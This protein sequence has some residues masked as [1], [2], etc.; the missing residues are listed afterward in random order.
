LISGEDQAKIKFK[1][2]KF[3]QLNKSKTDSHKATRRDSLNPNQVLQTS[4]RSKY[5]IDFSMRNERKS[6][7]SKDSQHKVHVVDIAIEK[8]LQKNS[9][10][11]NFDPLKILP[12]LKKWKIEPI[13]VSPRKIEINILNQTLKHQSHKNSK[14]DFLPEVDGLDISSFEKES[15]DLECPAIA[16]S[17]AKR[18]NNSSSYIIDTSSIPRMKDL[19]MYQQK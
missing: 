18:I 10:S 1:K 6:I 16:V 7:K 15:R 3:S 12:S 19:R 2:Y 4:I 14:I 13:S 8:V 17:E 11:N 9:W 5:N